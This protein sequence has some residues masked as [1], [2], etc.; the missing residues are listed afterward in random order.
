MF[1]VRD[2]P[3]TFWFCDADCSAK[4]VEYRHVYTIRK[5]LNMSPE[6]R[7]AALGGKSLDEHLLTGGHDSPTAQR[8]PSPS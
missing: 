6:E 7:N 4:W 1:R 5:L 8:G 2:G 3:A